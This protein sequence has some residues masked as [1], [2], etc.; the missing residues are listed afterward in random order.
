MKRC[1]YC[2]EE[3]E[4]TAVFCQYC[5]QDTRKPPSPPV[6]RFAPAPQQPV[7]EASSHGGLV[8]LLILLIVGLVVGGVW[9]VIDGKN[10]FPQQNN[11]SL[12][13]PN[14]ASAPQPQVTPT[15]WT[16]N[17][18][19]LI[20]CLE[21]TD[22]KGT[23]YGTT[24][25]AQ[26]RIA[27]TCPYDI[28]SITLQLV[29]LDNS[30]SV[31]ATA[32]SALDG[33]IRSQDQPVAFSITGK[34][35]QNKSKKF[36]VVVEHAKVVQSA[37]G[38]VH[39]PTL[40]ATAAPAGSASSS[41]NASSGLLTTMTRIRKNIQALAQ[42][43]EL[44]NCE[45]VLNNYKAVTNA[46]KFNATGAAQSAYN[47]YRAAVDI[48]ARTNKDMYLHCSAWVNGTATDSAVSRQ[49]WGTARQGVNEAL[50]AIE[51]GIAKLK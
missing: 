49:T 39:S 1:P 24:L 26:G 12:A 2:A 3:I 14:T 27:N 31:V 50:Q 36:R 13:S 23:D 4:D 47:D 45:S 28:R 20:E 6:R 44:I 29:M 46:P 19:K 51:A 21:I 40:K 8:M 5:G 25:T 9:F 32:A 38:A 15:H 48:I 35:L 11:D 33:D 22:L 42:D 30:G 18:A 7:Q 10:L 41:T 37:A 34:D 17:E 43:S 16:Q